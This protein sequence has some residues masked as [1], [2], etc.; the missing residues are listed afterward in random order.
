MQVSGK[1]F[2]RAL[3]KNMQRY[4][5]IDY[6]NPLCFTFKFRG[7]QMQTTLKRS[8]KIT[9]QILNLIIIQKN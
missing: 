8:S 1:R 6:N 7:Y 2:L 3:D 4:I 5:D 9:Q